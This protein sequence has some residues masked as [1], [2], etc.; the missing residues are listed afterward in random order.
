MFLQHRSKISVQVQ[1]GVIT[2]AALTNGPAARD[3]RVKNPWPGQDVQVVKGDDG[4]TVV[5]ADIQA[6]FITIPA[7]ANG[8]YLIQRP[9]APTAQLAK[10]ALTGTAPTAARHLVNTNVKIGLDPPA[11]SR[12]ARARHPR[13]RRCS[14]RPEHRRQHPRLVQLRPR[15]GLGRRRRHLPRDGPDGLQREHHRH[16]YLRTPTTTLGYLR[17][18][19]WAAE[20]KINAASSYRRIWDWKTGSGG[21]N[22]GFLIDLTPSGQVRTIIAGSGVTTNAVPATGRFIN[23]VITIGRDG[24]I[25]VYQDGT[26][27]GGGSY[28]STFAIDGCAPAEIRIGADQGG[29]QRISA[30]LDRT[31]MFTKALSE[32]TARAGSRWRSSTRSRRTHRSAAP[33]R[34]CCA[35][36]R[37]VER[38]PRHVRAGRHRRVHGDA[39]RHGHDDRARRGAERPRPGDDE[40]RQAG[41]RHLGDAAAAAGAGEHDERVRAGRRRSAATPLLSWTGPKS[42]D[43]IAITLKQPVAA[44]DGLHSGAY[45]K[46]LTFTLS[47]TTP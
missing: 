37:P 11:T 10:A 7:T 36:V 17:E 33:C 32:T 15:R 6:A 34:R 21:D 26:R 44:T 4:T 30:E 38:E 31:A 14:R 29:G 2:T 27:I 20:I 16:R 40:H 42:L 39:R 1:D 46:A 13:R 43:P 25:N 28:S 8:T 19:T 9:T 24:A 12:P 3:I 45:A 23:L 47:T 18:A 41:Q 35:H 22:V 5:V